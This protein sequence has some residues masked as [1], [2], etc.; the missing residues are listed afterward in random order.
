[1]K[2]ASI[3][4]VCILSG[5]VSVMAAGVPTTHYDADSSVLPNATGQIFAGGTLSDPQSKI[6]LVDLGGG[7]RVL[8]F[9]TQ[10]A[11]VNAGAF[12]QKSA[13]QSPVTWGVDRTV[14]YS[15]E[16]MLRF[17]G[18]AATEAGAADLIIGNAGRATSLRLMKGAGAVNAVAN[19]VSATNSNMVLG[20]TPVLNAAGFHTYRVDVLNDSVRL[21][22]N[23]ELLIDVQDTTETASFNFIRFG[24]ATGANDGKYQLQYLDTYQNGVVPEPALV[25]LLGAAVVVL[26]RRCLR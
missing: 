12:F 7:D 8:E 18:P 2:I 3:A 5:G 15:V 25:S 11:N 16:F 19:I 22:I 9:N 23:G 10:D 4:A 14:G 13:S 24:D 20:T 26:N 17:D 21:F 1:M 6:S